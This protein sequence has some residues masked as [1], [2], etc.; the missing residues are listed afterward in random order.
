M[1]QL[2]FRLIITYATSV[3]HLYAAR[4]LAGIATGVS[5]AVAPMYVGE[6]A[7]S[8]VRGKDIDLVP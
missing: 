7:E 5:C 1:V 8:S 4:L 2:I 6:I 3:W